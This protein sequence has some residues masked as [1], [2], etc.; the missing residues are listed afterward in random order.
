MI[1][2]ESRMNEA[3]HLNV[4]AVLTGPEPEWIDDSIVISSFGFSYPISLAMS[5]IRPFRADDLFRFNNMCVAFPHVSSHSM[6]SMT[7]RVHRLPFPAISTSGPK[8]CVTFIRRCPVSRAP[9]RPPQTQTHSHVRERPSEPDPCM[10]SCPYSY[11][12]LTQ[13]GLGFYFN[14][15][16]RW[17]DMCCTAQHPSGRLMGYG[18]CARARPSLFPSLPSLLILPCRAVPFI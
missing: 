15:L 1:D 12:C 18:T 10:S 5:I 8:R 13:Y 14:Y 3:I 7:L 4:N 16:S 17:P 6:N 9:T 2:D 11:P